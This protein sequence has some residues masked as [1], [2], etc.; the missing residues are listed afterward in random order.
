MGV[1]RPED[2]TGGVPGGGVG[3]GAEDV[4][5]DVTGGVTGGSAETDVKDVDL[6]VNSAVKE[7]E[8]TKVDWMDADEEGGGADD[9]FFL[10]LSM[11]LRRADILNWKQST[12]FNSRL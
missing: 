6:A 11:N 2:V 4:D 1:K 7:V 3:L 10:R 5:G 9:V 12:Q 8:D